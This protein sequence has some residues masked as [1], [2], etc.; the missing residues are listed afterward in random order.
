[1]LRSGPFRSRKRGGGVLNRLLPV[2]VGILALVAATAA[3]GNPLVD[4]HF[5]AR[6]QNL[7]LKSSSALVVDQSEGRTLYAKNARAVV[8]IASITKLMTAMVVLDARL[9]L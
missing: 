5:A 2:V 8:P 9:D 7:D 4:P 3:R 1:M 6:M